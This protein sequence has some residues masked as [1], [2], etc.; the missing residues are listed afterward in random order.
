MQALIHI[1]DYRVEAGYLVG[2]KIEKTVEQD[3]FGFSYILKNKN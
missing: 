2:R 1:M 3:L